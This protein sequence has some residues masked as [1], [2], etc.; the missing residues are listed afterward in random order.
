MNREL[1]NQIKRAKNMLEYY[2]KKLSEDEQKLKKVNL[3]KLISYISTILNI[4]C[5]IINASYVVGNLLNAEFLSFLKNA[6]LF[7]MF[8]SMAYIKTKD[9]KEYKKEYLSLTQDVSEDK[10]YIKTHEEELNKALSK[11]NELQNESVLES[12][13]T[14]NSGENLSKPLIRKRILK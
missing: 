6:A 7:T 2:N 8:L 4:I 14:L 13:F 3:L 9:Y 11:L 10:E 1:E 5:L 12:N